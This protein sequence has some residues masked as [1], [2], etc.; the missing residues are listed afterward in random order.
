VPSERAN[1]V[2]DSFFIFIFVAAL[3]VSVIV[4]GVI[5]SA[6]VSSGEPHSS[7]RPALHAAINGTCAAVLLVGYWLIRRKK[8]TAHAVFMILAGLLTTAFLVSYL[9]YHAGAGSTKF[10]GQG[11]AR[12]LYFTILISHTVLAAL[13]A[14]LVGS[15]Y[16]F[17]GTRQWG[18]HRKVARVTLPIWIYTSITGVLV[19]YMLHVW[20]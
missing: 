2:R 11:L 10:Q 9:D 18:K 15:L 1:P 13:V 12:G 16:W 14:P 17:A 5:E 20:F 6:P 7:F 4:I 19:Y 3:A 8:V